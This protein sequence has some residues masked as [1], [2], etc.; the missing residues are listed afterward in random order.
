[1]AREAAAR[2][3]E[4]GARDEALAEFVPARRRLGL[5]FAPRM[6]PLGRVWRLGVLLL[7]AEG[8][9]RATGRVVRAERPVRKS[10]TAE[11]VAEHRAYRAAAVKG[12]Y[13][14]GET[15]VFDAAPID[16]AA[17]AAGGS[18]G[19]L[20]VQG[21]RVLVRWSPNQPAAV[22]DFASYLRDRVGLLVDPPGG[23]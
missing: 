7:D 16:A 5:P 15:V 10:V 13:A 20:V 14:E 2:L 11:S 23:A 4:A 22:A 6:R 8:G 18:S 12:G 3:R 21:G 19:P 17:L 9:L 1:M